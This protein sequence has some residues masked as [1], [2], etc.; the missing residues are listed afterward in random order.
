MANEN[1]GYNAN[2]YNVINFECILLWSHQDIL[3]LNWMPWFEWE[4]L[5]SW[6]LIHAIQ[7]LKWFQYD[8]KRKFCPHCINIPAYFYFSS[9]VNLM[10]RTP[11]STFLPKMSH[12]LNR[13]GDSM[14]IMLFAIQYSVIKIGEGVSM[15][16]FCFWSCYIT[17]NA[18]SACTNQYRPEYDLMTASLNDTLPKAQTWM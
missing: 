10:L 4:M 12:A 7:W 6:M 2:K 5:C 16:F 15:I 17:N 9:I 14:Y 1:T 8:W 13:W 11:T 18:I 3:S